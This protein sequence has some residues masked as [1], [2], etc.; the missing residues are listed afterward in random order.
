MECISLIVISIPTRKPE[1]S[2]NSNSYTAKPDFNKRPAPIEPRCKSCPNDN[3]FTILTLN[4][5]WANNSLQLPHT[6]KTSLNQ[7]SRID[8][9]SSSQF[10]LFP[11]LPSSAL[12]EL[13]SLQAEGRTFAL[14]DGSGLNISLSGHSLASGGS[15][16]NI[17]R[18]ARAARG[19]KM[20][21]RGV[22][23]L[24]SF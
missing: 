9:V 23:K 8:K 15:Q 13:P 24:N 12:T 10:A 11:P 17:L 14:R 7:V 22:L 5:C 20:K 6:S 4:G 19:P 21:G 2:T 16:P 18:G 3:V 1:W